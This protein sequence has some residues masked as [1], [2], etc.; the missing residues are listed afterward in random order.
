MQKIADIENTFSLPT[1]TRS[2]RVPW[3]RPGRADDRQSRPGGARPGQLVGERLR[4]RFPGAAAEAVADLLG[5]LDLHHLAVLNDDLQGQ[6]AG[7][8]DLA[9]RHVGP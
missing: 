6:G 1:S 8:L 5:L 2:H 4:L 9:L 7:P 3:N